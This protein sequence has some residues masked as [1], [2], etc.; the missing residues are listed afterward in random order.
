MNSAKARWLPTKKE[1]FPSDRPLG[2]SAPIQPTSIAAPMVEHPGLA[3]LLFG[4]AS[5]NAE[6]WKKLR[7]ANGQLGMCAAP[8][9]GYQVLPGLK[10]M[11]VRLERHQKSALEIA[12]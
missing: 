2:M 11:G 1:I 4:T 3:D 8:D 10:T 9:D 5:A 6:H 12:Q 7:Q